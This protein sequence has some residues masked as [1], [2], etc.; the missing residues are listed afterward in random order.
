MS[1]GKHIKDLRMQRGL[2]Q[3]ELARLSGLSRSHLSRLELDSYDRSSAKTFLALARALKVQPTDLYQA[4]GYIESRRG[5]RTSTKPGDE[6]LADPKVVKLTAVPVVAQ[7]NSE[8]SDVVD[9]ACWGFSKEI[10]KNIIGLLVNGFHFKPDINEG[11]VIIIDQNK[12]PADGNIV[13][14]SRNGEAHLV[15]YGEVNALNWNGNSGYHL[16]GVVIGVN[17]KLA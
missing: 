10:G 5:P 11:D 1:L 2:S 4:A 14:C 8:V 17:K 16:Q 15:R 3:W 7:I 12:M 9:Y 6:T 13:L